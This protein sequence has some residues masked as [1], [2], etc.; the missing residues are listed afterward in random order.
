MEAILHVRFPF[1]HVKLTVKISYG[2]V[3]LGFVMPIPLHGLVYILILEMLCR[4][5]K[6]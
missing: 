2:T 5:S 3:Q 6:D 4:L 1:P